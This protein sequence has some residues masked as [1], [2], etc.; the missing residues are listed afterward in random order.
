MKNVK[1][2]RILNYGVCTSSD[3]MPVAPLIT[4][5]VRCLGNTITEA[6]QDICSH[7]AGLGYSLSNLPDIEEVERDCKLNREEREKLNDPKYFAYLTLAI[8]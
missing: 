1:Y 7:V 6:Y 4:Y 2:H 5:N 3:T 8:S